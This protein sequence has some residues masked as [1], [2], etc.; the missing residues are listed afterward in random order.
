MILSKLWYIWS[1]FEKGT[2][3]KP[4]KKHARTFCFL[5]KSELLREV[6]VEKTEQQNWGKKSGKTSN[7]TMKSYKRNEQSN[8]ARRNVCIKVIKFMV[9]KNK[10]DKCE[11]TLSQCSKLNKIQNTETKMEKE[12]RK[13][14]KLNRF[15][16]KLIWMNYVIKNK[17][18]HINTC[19]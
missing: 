15:G 18:P 3:G 12:T 14:S 11:W 4:R 5:L 9:L 13:L 7:I 6:N 16:V 19:Q 8:S 2:K 17:Y 10:N 1:G